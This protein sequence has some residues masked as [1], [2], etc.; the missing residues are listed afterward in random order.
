MRLSDHDASFLYG[1]TASSPMHGAVLTVLDGDMTYEEYFNQVNGRLHLVPRL[2][3]RLVY[4]PMNIAHPKWVPDPDFDLRNH[5]Q[6]HVVPTGTTVDDAMDIALELCEPLLDRDKPLWKTYFLEGVDGYTLLV[7]MVHH[8]MIDGA[9]GVAMSTLMLDFEPDAPV[10]GPPNE[11]WAPPA[12]PTPNELW[13]EA[14]AESMGSTVTRLQAPQ[15]SPPEQRLLRRANEVMQRFVTEPVITAPW[16]AGVVGPKRIHEWIEYD[17]EAFR[18]VKSKLGGSVNDL[19]LAVVSEAAARYL[20]RHAEQVDGQYMRLMCPVNVRTAE[21]E[22]ELGNRVSAMYPVLPAWA[23]DLTQRLEQVCEET[24]RIKVNQEAQAL[25]LQMRSSGGMVP[26]AAM[27]QALWVGT[28]F[29]PTV[30]A[31]QNPPPTLRDVKQRAPL[32]GF[33]FTCT[34][35]P[36]VPVQQYL[37]GLPVLRSLGTLMLGGTLGY[38]V[39]VATYNGKIII[40][41]TSD[42]RL[43]PDLDLMRQYIDECFKETQALAA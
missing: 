32:V 22:G 15:L 39:A 6:R 43:L 5:I 24:Q 25:D 34:N 33:N 4:V 13:T 38:G 40:N 10:P 1:E 18:G 31:A 14:M 27:S 7:Q 41:L 37:G 17:F 35:V 26:P 11:P 28:P 23:M 12:L 42:P 3:E 2:R 19:V 9:S 20:Q 16:N 29:D 8:A 21:D 36:G 30:A